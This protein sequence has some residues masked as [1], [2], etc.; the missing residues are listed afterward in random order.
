MNDERFVIVI[1][2]YYY[3]YFQVKHRVSDF[4][5]DFSDTRVIELWEQAKKKG[6]SKQELESIKVLL[7]SYIPYHP[8]FFNN[9]FFLINN[10][11][12]KKIIAEPSPKI[13]NAL[14]KS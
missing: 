11:P 8:S 7:L 12:F 5:G 13:E 2:Y 6:F 14:R 4:A 10:I 9:T 1:D 3:Y